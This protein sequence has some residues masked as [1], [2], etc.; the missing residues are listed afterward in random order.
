MGNR[1]RDIEHNSF[2]I[3]PVSLSLS[4]SLLLC[5]KKLCKGKPLECFIAAFEVAM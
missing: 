4:L 5:R 1:S 3:L 2:L